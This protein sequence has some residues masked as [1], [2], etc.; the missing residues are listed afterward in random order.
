MS[1]PLSPMP[2]NLI[3]FLTVCTVLR[4]KKFTTDAEEPLEVERVRAIG[5]LCD[6]LT[7][8]VRELEHAIVELT[9]ADKAG[10]E[11]TPVDATGLASLLPLCLVVLAHLAK[12]PRDGPTEQ[13]LLPLSLTV[14]FR[15]T[16]AARC[17][18]Y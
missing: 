13:A 14:P 3:S 4:P 10:K 16:N 18:V 15:M 5:V 17:Q 7:R 2:R 12:H 6:V 9:E 11:W 1:L 8:G